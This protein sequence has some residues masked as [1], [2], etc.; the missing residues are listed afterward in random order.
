MT[1]GGD[2]NI[3]RGRRGRRMGYPKWISLDLTDE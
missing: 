1:D 2:G 3:S